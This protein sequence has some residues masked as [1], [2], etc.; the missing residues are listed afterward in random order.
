[1]RVLG[2]LMAG[3]CLVDAGGVLFASRVEIK[4][5]AYFSGKIGRTGQNRTFPDI[6]GVAAKVR[7]ADGKKPAGSHRA[8]NAGPKVQ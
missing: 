4:G 2:G 8:A 6:G 7:R 3:Q 1:M 5:C